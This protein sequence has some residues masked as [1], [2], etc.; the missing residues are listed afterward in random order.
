MIMIVTSVFYHRF[1][2]VVYAAEDRGTAVGFMTSD[3][4]MSASVKADDGRG[5][6]QPKLCASSAACPPVV[7]RRSR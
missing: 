3:E 7:K 5:N 4:L 1:S 6:R 2:T